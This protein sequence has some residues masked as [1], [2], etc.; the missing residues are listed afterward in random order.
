MLPY[1]LDGW[2]L[3]GI[4]AEHRY[5]EV[6]EII[7]ERVGFLQFLPVLV[8]LAIVDQGIVL[9]RSLGLSEGEEA[10]DDHEE[11]DTSG[12]D[13]NL[14]SIVDSALMNLWSNIGL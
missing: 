5:D 2:S 3:G 7:G 9:F 12:E 14:S 8:H 10:N 4:V 13:V 1:L 6:F 11:D